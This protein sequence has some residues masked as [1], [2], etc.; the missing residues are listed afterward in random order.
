[1]D[2]GVVKKLELPLWKTSLTNHINGT[3]LVPHL[4]AVKRFWRTSNHP[5]LQ[6]L[7]NVPYD[8]NVVLT[9]LI[10]NLFQTL[11]GHLRGQPLRSTYTLWEVSTVG[12]PTSFSRVKVRSGH[13]KAMQSFLGP[14]KHSMEPL[15]H[16]VEAMSYLTSGQLQASGRG[17]CYPWN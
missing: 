4:T 8:I 16:L 11:Q 12:S 9:A 13:L 7:T 3:S 17:C 14:L 10:I 2:E 1:M 5:S 15:W 6:E